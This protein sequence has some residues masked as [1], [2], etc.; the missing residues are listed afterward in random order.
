MPT[1]WTLE[2]AEAGA[3]A[4][5]HR[6][7]VLHGV[8]CAF[9]EQDSSDHDAGLKPFTVRL[10]LGTRLTLTWLPDD[11]PPPAVI[12]TRLRLGSA[13]VEVTG[14]RM[15]KAALDTIGA[16]LAGGRVRF[17]TSSPVKFR[18]H[19]RDYPLPDPHLT[20]AGLARRWQR[21]HPVADDQS[22]RELVNAVVV[23]R[24]NIHTESFVWHGQPSAGFVGTVTFGLPHTCSPDL[25]GLFATLCGFAAFAGLGHGTTHGLGAVDVDNPAKPTQPG[26]G[27]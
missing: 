24:H 3:V 17:R 21:L 13:Q 22:I 15:H 18:H 2:L 16:N 26:A 25:R 10:D 4:G 1:Q 7:D 20:F 9:F 12:P 8:A 19:G 27:A 6:Y 14:F 23:Y 11:P 5:A